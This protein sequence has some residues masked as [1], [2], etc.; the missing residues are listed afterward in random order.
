MEW[1]D[2]RRLCS[3]KTCIYGIAATGYSDV[4]LLRVHVER[5]SSA[6][7]SDG[8]CN[9][10]DLTVCFVLHLQ[11]GCHEQQMQVTR[12]MTMQ[13]PR[14]CNYKDA[15]Q[16]TVHARIADYCAQEGRLTLEVCLYAQAHSCSNCI[17][18][19]AHECHHTCAQHTC[20]C[21][22]T[23]AVSAPCWAQGVRSSTWILTD[24]MRYTDNIGR[25]GAS[26]CGYSHARRG[27][28]R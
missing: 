26:G 23:H 11:S 18:D 24:G 19:Y 10:L 1:N 4:R 21:S 12:Q 16:G 22:G 5:C 25:Y 3:G 17:D 13:L 28:C 14:G 2:P 15:V 6:A 9:Q 20:T 27:G 7:M 8:G